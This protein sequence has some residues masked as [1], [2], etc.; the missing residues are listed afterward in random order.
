MASGVDTRT[1]AHAHTHTYTHTHTHT[2]AHTHTQA[3]TYFGSMKVIS[4]NQV[5]AWFKS[6]YFAVLLQILVCH[7]LIN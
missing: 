3:H 6:L 1:H 7:T 4:R 5:H 2:R